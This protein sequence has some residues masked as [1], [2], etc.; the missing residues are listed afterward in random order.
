MWK[1]ITRSSIG[2]SHQQSN[3]PCQDYGRYLLLDGNILIGAIADGAGSAKYADIGA[4][5]TV[6]ESLRFLEAIHADSVQDLPTNDPLSDEQAQ[7]LFSQLIESVRSRLSIVAT[8]MEGTLSDLASTLLV[9]I[10]TPHWLAG[11]Q[12]GDGFMVIRDKNAT[13]RL[14]FQPD[15]GEYINE[16][17]FVTSDHAIDT[18]QV[19]VLTE[20]P[21]FICAAT[22]GVER[23]SLNLVQW[24]PFAPFFEPLENYLQETE[25][26]EEEDDYLN[27]FLNS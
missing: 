17:T 18:L 8:E 24:M 2:T 14:L 25:N 1:V 26:P 22:D 13:Y 9:F 27:A 3:L 11:M 7:L 23:V 20:V 10:A 21:T 15:K 4:K 5:T 19:K 6:N 16:T 12:I